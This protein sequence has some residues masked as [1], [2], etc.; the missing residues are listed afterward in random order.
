MYSSLGHEG[1]TVLS[2]SDGGK[3]ALPVASATGNGVEGGAC[4]ATSP[5]ANTAAKKPSRRY[6]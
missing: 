3:I 5:K 6:R 1:F 4:K 2:N